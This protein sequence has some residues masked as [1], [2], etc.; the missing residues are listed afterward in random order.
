[1]SKYQPTRQLNA[2]TLNNKITIAEKIYRRDTAHGE[3]EEWTELGCFWAHLEF[4]REFTIQQH[5][6]S[7][8]GRIYL[9]TMRYFIDIKKGMRITCEDKVFYVCKLKKQNKI[10]IEFEVLQRI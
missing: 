10:C 5:E 6:I 1:M 7:K 8:S 4:Q 2:K 3:I 9:L